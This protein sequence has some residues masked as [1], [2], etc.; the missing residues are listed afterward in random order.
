MANKG[1]RQFKVRSKRQQGWW[2]V[3]DDYV[4][5][6]AKHLDPYATAIYMSL[7]RHADKDGMCFPSTKKLAEQHSISRTTV[8]AKIKLL[9][10]HHI[11]EKESGG[12]KK[13]GTF[14][15]NTYWLTDKTEWKYYHVQEVNKDNDR[16]H[17]VDK[18]CSS[19]DIDHV[20]QVDNKET[21]TKGNTYKETHKE[22]DLKN[23]NSLKQKLKEKTQMSTPAEKTR[24]SEMAAAD[25][26]AIKR[27]KRD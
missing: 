19:D 10:E 26:R 16:V 8:D 6:Y 4:N 5:G 20:Q 23:L 12:R 21:H 2:W 11:I 25:T 17:L 7:C 18:P 14:K 15:R 24:L 22:K 13:D 3:D 27:S 9:L 1:E